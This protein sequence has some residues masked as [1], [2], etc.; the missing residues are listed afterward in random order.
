MKKFLLIIFVSILI[1]ETGF[2]QAGGNV[3]YEQNNRYKQNASYNEDAEKVWDYRGDN[4]QNQLVI[5]NVNSNEMI[6]TVNAM[7]NV[8]AESFMAIFNIVQTGET[9][10]EVN[11]IVNTKIYGLRNELLKA[12]IKKEEIYTDMISLVP[13]YDYNVETKLFSKTYTEVPKGFEMQKNI[14][15]KFTN[16]S[17]L[18]KIVTAAAENE[19][20]DLIKVEYY[21]DN[22]DAKYIE[23]RNKSIDYMNSKIVAFKKLGINLDTVYHIISEKQSVV[24]P[25]DRYKS[26][27]A[28]SGTSIDALESKNV[29]K[30]RKP[31]TQFYNKLP[32]HKFDIVINPA[33]LEPVVQ[34]TYSLTLK[35]V[36]KEDK[37]KKEFILVTPEGVV[38]TLKI[39]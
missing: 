11:T 33:V 15:V 12:G 25:I 1:V 17:L 9:A 13:L 20:Y 39:D 3:I 37:T 2:S 21:V 30:V 27:Q 7:M 19:I 14:H 38:K 32:Y 6:F 8:K 22:T 16:D 34:F 23:L 26:Y 10:K 28:F 18:D 35:Y 5:E 31:V 36:I 29:T 4:N 24:Y